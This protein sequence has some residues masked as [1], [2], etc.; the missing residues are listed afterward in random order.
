MVE[1]G[2]DVGV[3]GARTASNMSFKASD[4]G[5]APPWASELEN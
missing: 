5:D 4:G 3:V 1:N 2:H